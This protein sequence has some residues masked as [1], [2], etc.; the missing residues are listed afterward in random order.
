MVQILISHGNHIE[1][2]SSNIIKETVQILINQY[3]HQNGKSKSCDQSIQDGCN[4]H[5][6]FHDFYLYLVMCNQ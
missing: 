4:Y 5:D 1:K 2:I 6:T 3:Q